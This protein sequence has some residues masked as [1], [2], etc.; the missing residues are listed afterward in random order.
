MGIYSDLEVI[1]MYVREMDWRRQVD[2]LERLRKRAAE[3]EGVCSRWE[4]SYAA[5]REENRQLSVANRALAERC[6]SLSRSLG[7][8]EYD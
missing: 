6:R 1:E 2:E 3:L 8:D 5:M 7:L 4:E